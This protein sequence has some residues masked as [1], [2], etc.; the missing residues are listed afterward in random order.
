MTPH[1]FGAAP[2]EPAATD[3]SANRARRRQLTHAHLTPRRP[4]QLMR[5]LAQ[6]TP[7][8]VGGAA[9]SKA[10]TTLARAVRGAF[11]PN[12]PTDMQRAALKLAWETGG[13]IAIQGPPGTG[14]TTVINA[15]PE[16]LAAGPGAA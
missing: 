7:A 5:V 12:E 8:A 2:R 3:H 11:G 14:Q 16:L 9:R 10:L 4:Y 6:E 13:L 1:P 15:T